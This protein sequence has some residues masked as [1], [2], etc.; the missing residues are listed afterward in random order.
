MNRNHIKKFDA[1]KGEDVLVRIEARYDGREA[2][3][4]LLQDV[5]VEVRTSPLELSPYTSGTFEIDPED[6]KYMLVKVSWDSVRWNL[7]NGL[8]IK[9]FGEDPTAGGLKK[10]VGEAE[11]WYKD[12]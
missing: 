5:Q 9:V 1:V 3:V 11:V 10:V 4:G 8:Y 12:F 6:P 2:W 7:G